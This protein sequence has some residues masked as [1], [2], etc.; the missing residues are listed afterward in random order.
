MFVSCF[1]SQYSTVGDTFSER[2]NNTINK[3]DYF[4]SLQSS[5]DVD[6]YWIIDNTNG[7]VSF[8]CES[9]SYIN[10]L[11]IIM[12]CYDTITV[13][14]HIDDNENKLNTRTENCLS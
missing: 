12:F 8:R 3:C 10:N 5:R 4:T 6:N 13:I 1:I 11:N 9:R 14:R 7:D 2:F